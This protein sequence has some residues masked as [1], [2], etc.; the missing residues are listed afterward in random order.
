MLMVRKKEST[1]N[2]TSALGLLN[3]NRK[4]KQPLFRST[5]VLF[6]FKADVLNHEET[7]SKAAA[8][9][10]CCSSLL[11]WVVCESGTEGLTLH[12]CHQAS[13]FKSRFNAWEKEIHFTHFI[14]SQY[15]G[16]WQFYWIAMVTVGKSAFLLSSRVSRCWRGC[17]I[18]LYGSTTGQNIVLKC[19]QS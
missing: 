4:K 9:Q 10:S 2:K 3:E 15:R 13:A 5:S 1:W 11:G 12:A 16:L 8:A 18:R 6:L 7:E 19:S 14:L 17:I